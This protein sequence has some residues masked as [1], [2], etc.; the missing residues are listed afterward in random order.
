M[1]HLKIFCR[2]IYINWICAKHG[3]EEFILMLPWFAS[4]RFLSF[5][6][7]WYWLRNRYLSRAQRLREAFEELGP[8]FVKFG[9]MLSTRRDIIPEDIAIELAKLQDCVPPFAGL[10][11]VTILEEIYKQPVHEIFA[12]FSVVPLASASIAQVHAARLMTGEEVVV[13]L[14]RPKIKKKIASDVRVMKAMAKLIERY[15]HGSLRLRPRE[16]VAEFA[17]TLHDELD[18]Q[19]EGANA[20]QLKRNFL[21]SSLLY[22]PQIYWPY[23]TR[24]VLVMERI[25][26]VPISDIQCFREKK[27]NLKKLAEH[28]VEIFFTQVFRD[29]FFHADMHPGNVFVNIDDP[30]NPIYTAVDFGIMGSLNP[31]DQRYLAENFLAFFERD[32]KRVAELHIASRWVDANTRVDV[33]EAAIRA[34]CEP[35]F[36]K[37]L[38]DISCAQILIRLFETA[39]QFNM[40]IQPQLLMLQ[41]TL[42]NVEGLG[43]M[44]Y[45]ELDLWHTAKPFLERFVR[46]QKSPLTLL[47]KMWCEIPQW[48]EKL[49]QL[50]EL[51]QQHLQIHKENQLLLKEIQLKKSRRKVRAQQRHTGFFVLG[52]LGGV[53]S[54]VELIPR[55]HN[56]PS[57]QHYIHAYW[58]W[59][60]LGLS[61]LLIFYARKK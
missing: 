27:V 4:I 10:K 30:E 5:F 2:L 57:W 16:V 56:I 3:L 22:V 41:K 37:P 8:I 13:K 58:P 14:L 28:G 26:G 47:K 25:Y 59:G 44:L 48:I 42:L 51:M 33:F 46:A 21:N 50:P 20:A 61:S 39:R 45:P 35:M 12:E 53:W 24:R 55:F 40:E 34:V 15:W 38:K 29:C 36:G 60:L 11:A 52:I 18:L 31:V 9:Q 19:R 49:P 32:Y 1:N 23:T 6:N 7:P 43:R 54:L 17:R